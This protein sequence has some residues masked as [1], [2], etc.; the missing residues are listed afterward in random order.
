M[1][2][3]A[4]IIAIAKAFEAGFVYGTVYLQSL[5]PEQQHERA[6]WDIEDI[7]RLREIGDQFLAALK[8]G[9]T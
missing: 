6:Q 4:A 9:T 2:T 8:K 5:S 3:E 1:L 7:R